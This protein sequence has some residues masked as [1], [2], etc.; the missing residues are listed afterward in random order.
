MANF[1]PARLSGKWYE[2]VRDNQNPWTLGTSCVT[3][4]F[5]PYNE[6][7]KKLDLYFRCHWQMKF[8]YMGIGGSLYQCDEGS[9]NS[10]TCKATMGSSSKRSDFNIFETDYDNYEILYYCS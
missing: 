5:S 2:V 6:Q 1:D 7:E 10:W 8:G 4:E 3:K 9:A